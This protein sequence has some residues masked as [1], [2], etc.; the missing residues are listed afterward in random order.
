MSSPTDTVPGNYDNAI[1]LLMVAFVILVVACCFVLWCDMPSSIKTCATE[2]TASGVGDVYQRSE[3]DALLLDK[4]DKVDVYVKSEVYP[5]GDV[6]TFL[7]AKAD[8]SDVFTKDLLYQRTDVDALLS[9][10]PGVGDVYQKSEADALLLDKADKSGVYAK[11]EVYPRSNIDTF[12]LAKADGSDVYTKD[13]LYQKTDVDALLSTKPGVGD[14]YQKIE[15]DAL[16]FDKADKVDVYLKNEVY[17]RSDV[18]AFLLAKA[19]GSDVFTKD[20]LYQK[21]DVD[22]LLSNKPDKGGVYTKADVDTL[23]VALAES[24]N[25]YTSAYTG[26]KTVHPPIAINQDVESTIYG[27]FKVFSSSVF[28]SE[29]GGPELAFN[30]N[31][32]DTWTTSSSMY[33]T[34]NSGGNAGQYL[35]NKKHH[36]GSLSGEWIGIELPYRIYIDKFVITCRIIEDAPRKFQIFGTNDDVDWYL[37]VAMGGI[38]WA[39]DGST[40]TFN[41]QFNKEIPYKKFVL[42]INENNARNVSAIAEFR[43]HTPS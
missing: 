15:A 18:D 10:K 21:T 28:S 7:L 30:A 11:N 6:D 43:L 13:L 23:L 4:A 22:A 39:S 35:G 41:S 8:G 19:D 40:K 20:L 24:V 33:E 27:D 9:T 37:L 29:S 38:T 31:T 25:R 14:V 17:P 34:D 12:L 36:S 32:T 16:L 1:L 26:T 42:V 3:A 2:T 5:R